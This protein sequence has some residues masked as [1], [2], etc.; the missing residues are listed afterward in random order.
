MTWA[1]TIP[2][3]LTLSISSRAQVNVDSLHTVWKDVTQPDNNRL[4]ALDELTF[5]YYL[6]VK[7]QL[8]S[9][10]FY[11][12]KMLQLANQARLQSYGGSHRDGI[13]SFVEDFDVHRFWPIESDDDKVDDRG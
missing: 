6:A 7:L 3:L 13:D 2:L 4:Q 10:I 11:C 5:D 1:L 8:G 12:Q 9:T